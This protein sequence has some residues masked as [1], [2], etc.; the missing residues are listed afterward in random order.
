MFYQFKP[1]LLLGD[2]PVYTSL[3]FSA[4]KLA[5]ACRNTKNDGKFYCSRS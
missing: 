5:N 4:A 1:G 3:F 2:A